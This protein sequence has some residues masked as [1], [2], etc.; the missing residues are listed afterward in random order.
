MK[1]MSG[2]RCSNTLAKQ[3]INRITSEESLLHGTV[4][5]NCNNFGFQRLGFGRIMYP[6]CILYRDDNLTADDNV[7]NDGFMCECVIMQA[8]QQVQSNLH[9]VG[10]DSNISNYIH[11]GTAIIQFPIVCLPV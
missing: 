2:Q 9:S 7:L 8:T 6:N 1:D 11:E 10:N 4:L 5:F 3:K